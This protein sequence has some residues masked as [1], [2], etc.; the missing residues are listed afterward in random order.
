[1]DLPTSKILQTF[2]L[3]THLPS[4]LQLKIWRYAIS[5]TTSLIVQITNLQTL[6]YSK[7]TTKLP[8]PP[9]VPSP[10]AYMPLTPALSPSQCWQLSFPFSNAGD[11]ANTQSHPPEIILYDF[12]RCG[13]IFWLE[14]PLFYSLSKT[15]CLN[16]A[17]LHAVR[18]ITICITAWS[19]TGFNGRRDLW[20]EIHIF[21][22]SR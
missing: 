18:R 7:P 21:S 9:P 12:S 2:H 16:S 20:E 5:S 11:G 3:S 17:D 14:Q 4:E 6:R 19:V 13:D 10:P 8:S 1:M 22:I 15:Q